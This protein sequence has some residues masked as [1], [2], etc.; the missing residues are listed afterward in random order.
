MSSDPAPA[1]PAVA[2]FDP[3][4]WTKKIEALEAQ[5]KDLEKANDHLRT[6]VFDLTGEATKKHNEASIARGN[7]KGLR[8][9]VSRLKGIIDK[10]DNLKELAR[11]RAELAECH[12]KLAETSKV[13]EDLKKFTN[14][15]I[16]T[17]TLRANKAEGK[18]QALE[19]TASMMAKS[20][21][22]A[23]ESAAKMQVERDQAIE[24]IAQLDFDL[25]EA[26]KELVQ[27]RAAAVAAKKEVKA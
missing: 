16:A 2:S 9:E 11:L 27:L 13:Q 4:E 8:E 6:K 25:K 21:D 12:K 26:A 3:V 24:K 19:S 22:N 1:A 7:E 15:T 20:R 10:S 17:L 5:N 23:N 14:D 18:F